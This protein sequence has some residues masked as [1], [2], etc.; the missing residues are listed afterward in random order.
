MARPK[1]KIAKLL[2]QYVCVRITDMTHVDIG[3]FHFDPNSTLYCFVLNANEQIYLRYGGRDDASA[4]MYLNDKS[5]ELALERGLELHKQRPEATPRPA[6]AWPKDIPDVRDN[7]IAKKQCV[8]C[9]QIGHGRTRLLQS[10]GK[11]DKLKDVW[12]YPE[13]KRLGIELDAEKG[14]VVKKADG[15]GKDAGIKPRDEIIKVRGITVRSYGDLQQAVHETPLDAET[16]EL[17]L[18]RGETEVTASIKLPQWWRVTNIERRS[19]TH[20]LEPFPEFWAKPLTDAE[21]R[22]HNIKPGEFGAAVTKFW[23]KTNGQNAGMQVGD[24]VYE[25]DGVTGAEYTDSPTL[26]I[27]L[28]CKA[29]DTVEVKVIRADKRLEFSFK[30]KARPW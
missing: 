29:G 14:T 18:K 24:I 26:W 8:H 6:A 2:A 23:V 11:I 27:R 12:H 17:T 4:D 16:L 7:V 1:G 28:N 15:A 5:L 10:Q 22:K 13:L 3:L 20:A 30:L 25:V 19:S 9:H 21:K